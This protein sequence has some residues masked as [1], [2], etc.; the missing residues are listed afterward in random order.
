MTADND[1]NHVPR[2][3]LRPRAAGAKQLTFDEVSVS[4]PQPSLS[5]WSNHILMTFSHSKK[6]PYHRWY[7][8]VEGFSSDYLKNIFFRERSVGNVF[9]PFAG[10]GTTLLEASTLGIPSFY[11][12]VNP[13]MSFVT[14]TKINGSI[15]LKENWSQSRQA[16]LRYLSL[17]DSDVF[18]EFAL[19]VSL[20]E[21]EAAFP[22]RDYFVTRD[23][24]ELLAAR[25]LAATRFSDSPPVRD[26]ILLALASVTVACSNMT[27]RADL[28][29]RR[30]G[31]YKTRVVDVPKSVH[32]KLTEMISDLD[33][34]QPPSARTTC[35]SQNALAIPTEY[36]GSFEMAITSPPYL[37]GTNYLRN[38]KLE[39]WLLGY[40]SAERDLRPLR[41][42]TVPSG[43]TEV[44]RST[45]LKHYDVVEE[46]AVELDKN[47]YDDRIPRLVRSYFDRMFEALQQTFLCLKPGA[48]FIVDIGDSKF[49][50]IHI[51]TDTI[52]VELA[53]QARFDA[54]STRVLA[55][56][57]SL[58]KTP[59]KQ[60]EVVL[61]KS[62]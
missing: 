30:P 44:M 33:D 40:I 24:K 17:L 22:K 57:Y 61:Q 25:D 18:S 23:L 8:Y 26:L 19:K 15:A 43:I 56:R 11:S 4:A 39:L 48:K 29:R 59:L 5:D 32:T 6:R 47:A 27:R 20:R 28:R 38:T 16:L 50:G 34:A 54:V 60:V 3:D 49:C 42:A 14:Q 58:D 9:D 12:E 51:P 35:V 13:F 62:Q 7:P 53:K 37:N 10:C 45:G 55:K 41:E 21:Y 2:I 1:A 46:I 36:T 52:I 31:E